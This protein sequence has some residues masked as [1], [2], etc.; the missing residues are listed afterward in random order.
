[1]YLI[2]GNT[3]NYHD[4]QSDKYVQLA[5]YVRKELAPRYLT[6]SEQR[7]MMFHAAALFIRRLKHQVYYTPA[8]T[9]KFYAVGVKTLN[10]FLAQYE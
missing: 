8:N 9:L 10:D 5:D 6:E 3:I 1:V 4:Y 7:A 2:D